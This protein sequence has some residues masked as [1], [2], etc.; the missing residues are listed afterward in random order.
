MCA[1]LYH[2]RPSLGRTASSSLPTAF[3]VAVSPSCPISR[4]STLGGGTKGYN[5]CQVAKMSA[6]P[7]STAGIKSAKV[8][9]KQTCRVSMLPCLARKASSR[10]VARLEASRPLRK[11]LQKTP[12]GQTPDSE[13]SQIRASWGA[14]PTC[15]GCARHM[16]KCYFLPPKRARL[17]EGW[18][19]DVGWEDGRLRMKTDEGRRGCR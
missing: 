13:S 4:V 3:F 16:P 11:L 8:V 1:F 19:P 17:A 15:R 14:V 5:N 7:V 18:E 10:P 9:L 12:H 6:P 2:G